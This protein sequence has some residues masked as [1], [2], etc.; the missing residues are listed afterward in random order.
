M[1]TYVYPKVE[2]EIKSRVR[3]ESLNTFS[4]TKQVERRLE[5]L[6]LKKKK[7]LI[8]LNSIEREEEALRTLLTK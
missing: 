2:I 7:V 5:S 4:T 1:S 3:L 8:A 6:S